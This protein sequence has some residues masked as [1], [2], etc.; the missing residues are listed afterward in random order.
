MRRRCRA[1]LCSR[2]AGARRGA[3]GVAARA[4]R[5]RVGGG[6]R[7]LAQRGGNDRARPA[8]TRSP[9]AA[10]S[11]SASTSARAWP[12]SATAASSPAKRAAGHLLRGARR[13]RAAAARRPCAAARRPGGGAG[14]LARRVDAG[15]RLRRRQRRHLPARR[16]AAVD[17]RVAAARL[18][19]GLG[20][21][22]LLPDD[23]W[24]WRSGWESATD[25]APSSRARPARRP[26]ARR[27]PVAPTAPG[28]CPARLRRVRLQGRLRRARRRRSA[29][30]CP[31]SRRAWSSAPHRDCDAGSCAIVDRHR[32]SC[33]VCLMRA[34]L[35]HP[36]A[37]R[38]RC[39]SPAM[40][41]D[42]IDPAQAAAAAV[43]R[44][45]SGGHSLRFR[46]RLSDG[47]C[48]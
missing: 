34:S 6:G 5:R 35:A 20:G 29:S 36:S 7:R 32:E 39:A 48:K 33:S 16:R 18:R 28:T 10:S 43:H 45:R 26:R 24:L 30:A 38:S 9:A 42:D 17:D 23:S 25:G 27:S 19:L 22:V 47:E 12:S 41:Q 1:G 31:T 46:L 37:S 13:R 8:S 14:A 40:S 11:C 2:S 44:L 21:A 4:Y 15:R 3:G